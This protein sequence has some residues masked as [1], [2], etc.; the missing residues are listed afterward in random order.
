M[1]ASPT[2]VQLLGPRLVAA[3]LASVLLAATWGL[4][5]QPALVEAWYVEGVVP[6][7]SAALTGVT[8]WVPTSLAEWVE[9]GA[10]VGALA[11]LGAAVV[12]L[13]RGE[14]RLVIA[15]RL[16]AEAW[17]AVA[18]AL[19]LFYATWG[20]AY[21]R[22]RI[23]HRLGWTESFSVEDDELGSLAGALV[24]QVNDL[25]LQ[26]H[27]MADTG[28]MTGEPVDGAAM[29]A[30]ID[31][32]WARM[33]KAE[34]LHPAVGRSR[35]PTKP[36]LS[37]GVFTVLGIGGF[38]F[39]YTGEAN[40]NVWSPA[41]QQPHTRAHEMAHQRFFASENEANFMGFLACIYSDD[42]L[43]RYSGW[44]FAQRQVLRAL[45][46]ADPWLGSQHLYARLPGVQ[47]DVNLSR[48]FWT[49]YDG[50]LSDL[51]T[52]INDVYLKANNV[53]GGVKSYGLSLRLLVRWAR[54]CGALPTDDTTPLHGTL[55][56][57]DPITEPAA[58]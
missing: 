31:A 52:S 33:A 22:P 10:A 21:S 15:G 56:D 25:Y 9:V 14:R 32:G 39:P 6:W 43:V 51:S 18:V 49:R 19:W 2:T 11:W 36:L 41:W 8:R 57:C 24:D 1:S 47:T 30:A 3:L 46:K 45:L 7:V 26:L 34:G 58:P 5:T 13:A 50:S 40:I 12:R 35:G 54:R 48:A 29:D 28:V 42:P 20:L 16:L 17:A 27:Q 44:L 38:Y 53:E 4:G 37:S 55:G 23:E